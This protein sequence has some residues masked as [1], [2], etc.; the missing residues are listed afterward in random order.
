M[1]GFLAVRRGMVRTS[2]SG[3]E[4][5]VGGE[6]ERGWSGREGGVGERV[7]WERGGGTGREGLG[8]ERRLERRMIELI[9]ARTLAR[10]STESTICG[11]W[12]WVRITS[13]MVVWFRSFRLQQ[14]RKAG[15]RSTRKYRRTTPTAKIHLTNLIPLTS[16]TISPTNTTPTAGPSEATCV[17]EAR[18]TVVSVPPAKTMP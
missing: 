2:G 8:V 17:T 5:R 6:W 18:P 11:S 13:K 10:R 12:L 4:G 15:H 16:L 14:M 7:D 3:R 1:L 9:Q